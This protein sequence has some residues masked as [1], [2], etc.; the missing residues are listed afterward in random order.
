MINKEILIK[1]DLPSEELIEVFVAGDGEITHAW[2]DNCYAVI[3]EDFYDQFRDEA[4]KEGIIVTLIE[5]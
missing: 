4:F 2:D 5:G 3:Q 1:G